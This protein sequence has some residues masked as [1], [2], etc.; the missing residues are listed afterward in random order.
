VGRVYVSLAVAKCISNSGT[1][2]IVAAGEA[3]R[4]LVV[5]VAVE[6]EIPGELAP[7]L[8]VVGHVEIG[9]DATG[10]GECR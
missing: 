9:V 8:Y 10:L 5:P 6:R 2:S 1:G 7:K 3:W 4:R